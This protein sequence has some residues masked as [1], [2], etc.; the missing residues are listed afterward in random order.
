MKLLSLDRLEKWPAQVFYR[1]SWVMFSLLQVGCLMVC[2]LLAIAV[3]KGTQT[4]DVF[5]PVIVLWL[6]LTCV[7][8]AVINWAKQNAK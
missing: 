3:F 7:S 1:L 6:L 4:S 8:L 2:G 5:A